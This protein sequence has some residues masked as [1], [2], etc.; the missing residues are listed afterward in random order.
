V[1]R[2]HLQLVEAN[3]RA[4]L[5]ETSLDL[6]RPADS[7]ELADVVDAFSSLSAEMADVI[8]QWLLKETAK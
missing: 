8:K 1:I 4:I 3:G 2:G 7:S 5:A 6:S